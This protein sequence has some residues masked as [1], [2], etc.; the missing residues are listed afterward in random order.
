MTSTWK[1]D[2]HIG[3]AGLKI[4]YMSADSFAF[5]QKICCSFLQMEGVGHWTWEV[6][7]LVIFCVR[8][9][10]QPIQSLEAVISSSTSSH[11]PDKFRLRREQP[12]SPYP[13]PLMT[14]PKHLLLSV[15]TEFF[16]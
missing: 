12:P 11:K 1:G 4:C 16:M 13:N 10:L 8:L 6:T 3:E 7:K 9:K 15:G 5:E 2:S 14:K